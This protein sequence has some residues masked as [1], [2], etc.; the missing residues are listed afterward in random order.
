HSGSHERN[1]ALLRHPGRGAGSMARAAASVSHCSFYPLRWSNFVMIMAHLSRWFARP[2]RR[3]ATGDRPSVPPPPP[4]HRAPNPA[5]VQVAVNHPA[6]GTVI[7]LK[8]EAGV[9]CAGALLNGLLAPA[10]CRPAVVTIDLSELNSIS[11]LAVG[12]LAAY[13]RGVVRTGGRVRL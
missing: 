3:A 10:A 11:C 6:D 5:A 1:D 4:A 13:R 9:G 12:V 8:G 7:R 2:A